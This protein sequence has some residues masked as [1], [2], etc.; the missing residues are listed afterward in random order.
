MTTPLDSVMTPGTDVETILQRKTGLDPMDGK[1][2]RLV[3][4]AG[5]IY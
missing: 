5:F 2:P 4:A 3:G 1:T